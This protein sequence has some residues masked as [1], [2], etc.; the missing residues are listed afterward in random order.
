MNHSSKRVEV[1]GSRKGLKKR[2]NAERHGRKEEPMP[3]IMM[4][5]NQKIGI[6]KKIFG[7]KYVLVLTSD[8]NDFNCK[9]HG[10]KFANEGNLVLLQ[11]VNNQ[12]FI[13]VVFQQHDAPKHLKKMGFE[14]PDLEV[15]KYNQNKVKESKY[16]TNFFIKTEEDA[17]EN[18]FWAPSPQK[19]D[20]DD[21]D[22]D[23]D[24]DEDDYNNAAGSA[25]QPVSQPQNPF[26]RGSLSISTDVYL[27]YYESTMNVDFVDSEKVST[28]VLRELPE[29]EEEEIDCMQI[30]REHD[31]KNKGGMAFKQQ[32]IQ[33]K[34]KSP[35]TPTPS[36][37][38]VALE[39]NHEGR[40]FPATVS[41]WDNSNSRGKVTI[42]QGEAF[43]DSYV[44][45]AKVKIEKGYTM[46]VCLET[47]EHGGLRVNQVRNIQAPYQR[48]KS[49]L[50]CGT[51]KFYNAAKDY[52]FIQYE[53]RDIIFY[54]KDFD[55]SVLPLLERPKKDMKLSFR[56]SNSG[57]GNAVDVK[58]A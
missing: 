27:P 48:P 9:I 38:S 51:L 6:V 47:N 55:P 17:E 58:L 44:L 50:M 2:A 40:V 12:A 37:P 53:G 31:A 34:E 8:G 22:F 16:A 32:S 23:D 13:D 21:S 28:G 30:W 3:E 11:F 24:E 39:F 54:K 33:K 41:F 14:I 5:E 10:S 7:N 20:D 18:K 26:V 15:I 35:K 29:E 42:P 4:N 25:P 57:K 49:P 52:G 43:F 45:P 19:D 36:S 56:M 1:T 46:E